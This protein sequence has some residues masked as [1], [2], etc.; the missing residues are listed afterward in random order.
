MRALV[1]GAS[2][3]LGGRLAQ[4]LAGRGEEVT[5]LAR[6]RADLRHLDGCPIRVVR[7]ALS[8]GAALHDAVRDRTH[9]FNC[10]AHSSDW[11]PR[12]VFEE[13]N[14]MGV[15]NLLAA[16]RRVGG[17][18]RFVH[19]STTDV[20]GY[21]ART[22]RRVASCGRF[23]PALQQHEMRGGGAGLGVAGAMGCRLR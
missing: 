8:D 17:F 10:A 7:G 23:R 19:V 15:A 11:G 20:Y 9:V 14:V 5:V 21:P 6:A 13:A 3:F 16:A 18:E 1:T 2:G 22:L 4:I 12:R